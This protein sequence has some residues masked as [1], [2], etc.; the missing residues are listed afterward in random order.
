MFTMPLCAVDRGVPYGLHEPYTVCSTSAFWKGIR[1][2]KH[3]H[4]GHCRKVFPYIQYGLPP[5]P[6]PFLTDLY[7]WIFFHA[8]PA[9]SSSLF[10][11]APVVKHIA[12]KET[13]L[14]RLQR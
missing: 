3:P 10:G 9:F 5:Y 13:I 2:S 6:H 12:Y 7:Y 8:K 14:F 1:S 4:L 11:S